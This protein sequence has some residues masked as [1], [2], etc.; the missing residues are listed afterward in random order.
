MRLSIENGRAFVLAVAAYCIGISGWFAQPAVITS[1]TDNGVSS[2]LAGLT[3]SV[4]LLGLSAVSFLL[5]PNISKFP[6][7]LLMLAGGVVTVGAQL[8]SMALIDSAALLVA[9]RGLAGVGEGILLSA[10]T[11]SI[12]SFKDPDR[13]YAEVNVVYTL[14]GY[15]VLAVVS[16]LASA[17]GLWTIFATLG[18]FA[19]LL[20]PA[21]LISPKDIQL[22]SKARPE[23]I[24]GSKSYAV[25]LG[26]FAYGAA[27]ATFWA[28]LWNLG[29]PAGFTPAMIGTATLVLGVSGVAGG[30]LAAAISTRFGRMLPITAALVLAVVAGFL[31]ANPP[32]V[33]GYLIGGGLAI[34]TLHFVNPFILG[35]AADLDPRGGPATAT[36]GAYFFSAVFGP[37]IG[38][39][40]QRWTGDYSGFGL[41]MLGACAFALLTV[42][43]A[44]RG[45]SKVL[46]QPEAPAA[47]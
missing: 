25:V 18:V 33:L 37:L 34:G 45:G 14:L 10:A 24:S 3:A 12:A 16:Y 41:L 30:A 29:E 1:L 42:G 21:L 38:G 26:M 36:S 9:A 27:I 40:L 17:Y 11:A 20:I 46:L 7:K 44:A 13:R 39:Y 22:I 19:L 32:S 8:L 47:E 28:F 2:E 15:G 6:G 5:A 23:R 35:V 31:L 43:F 4:E